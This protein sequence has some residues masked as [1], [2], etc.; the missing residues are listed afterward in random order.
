MRKFDRLSVFG[1]LGIFILLVSLCIPSL[2]F[3]EDRLDDAANEID[4]D[5]VADS[6]LEESNSSVEPVSLTSQNERQITEAKTDSDSLG[7]LILALNEKEKP[8]AAD[9]AEEMK[10]SKDGEEAEETDKEIVADPI[11]PVNRVMFDFN[12]KVYFVVMK[13]FYGAYNSVL[14]EEARIAGRNFFDNLAM[15]VRFVSCFVQIR[16]KCAGIEL[17][18]FS[19]NSTIGMAGLFD[20][21]AGDTF[22]LKPQEADIGLAIG[23]YGIGE[24]FY[25]VLP[26]MGPS[27]L[28]DTVGMAGDSFLTPYSYLNP[29]YVPIAISAANFV[30][31]G[32]LQYTEYEELKKAAID[33]YVA[34]KDAYIQYR[35]GKIK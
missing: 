30:N 13:P 14:P 4:S 12:D 2:L 34:L 5:D 31:R 10:A 27:S 29:F 16:P 15:P 26:F 8:Q 21:A 33:P 22:K 17:A 28:R 7:Q 6:P 11:E 9:P 19:I 23:H 25:L 24:G 32:S 35:R 1:I 18:R 20:I 3:A